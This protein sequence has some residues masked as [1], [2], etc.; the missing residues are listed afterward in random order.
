M[1]TCDS[2]G[3]VFTENRSLTRHI[4]SVHNKNSFNCFHC[5]F[6]SNRKDSL[7]RHIKSK[8]F[9]KCSTNVLNSEPQNKKRRT[10][11]WGDLS[12]MDNLDPFVEPEKEKGQVGGDVR[13]ENDVELENQVEP[14][15]EKGQVGGDDGVENNVELENQ[16]FKCPDCSL[17]LSTRGSLYNHIKVKHSH[18]HGYICDQ[19]G[20]GFPRKDYLIKHMKKHEKMNAKKPPTKV[21][22]RINVEEEPR[23]E[24]DDSS[25]SESAFNRMLLTKTWRIRG[26]TDPLSLMAKYHSALK[27][28]LIEVL[29]KNAVK[30]YINV[31][32]TMVRKD[33]TGIKARSSSYLHGSTR[34][35]LRASQ[36]PEM[37]QSS[38]EKINQ[39]F[40]VFLKNG[41][42]WVLESIDYL[43]LFTAE[44]A[45]MHGNR[46]IPTP[47][48]IVDKHAIINP[49]NENEHCVMYCLALSQHYHEIDQ[50]NPH[51]P[52]QLE[53]FFDEYN[54]DGCSMPMEIDDFT[55]FEK[56]NNLAIN[57]YHIKHDG[58]LITPLRITQQE[59]KLEEYVNL[60]LIEGKEHCHYAWI[61]NLDR[62]LAYG[63]NNTRKFCPF[64]L[65]GFDTRYKKTLEEHLPL[66]REYGGQK[67]ILPA[68]GKNIIEFKDHHKCLEHPIVIYADFESINQQVDVDE[69]NPQ[70][71]GTTLNTKHICS[72]YSYTVV[73]PHCPNRVKTYR[74]E[75]AGKHFLESVMEE[76]IKI[77]KWL[78]EIEKKEHNLNPDEEKQWQAESKCHI[79][80][81]KFYKGCKPS[82]T[83]NEHLK[84]HLKEMENLL[85]ANK[86]DISKIPSLKL[87][88]KQKR[89]ISLQLHPDKLGDVSNEEKHAKEEELKIFNVEN[90][91]LQNYLLEHEL[92][93]DEEQDEE[94]EPE[95]DLTA[96]EIDRIK[97]KGWKV[98]DHDHWTGQYRGAAHSGCN[99]ALRKTRKIPVIFH[100]LTGKF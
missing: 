72:G 90:E 19:C 62:L 59:G 46:Y 49:H 53:Q 4:T 34:I 67:T 40:D 84:K 14:E 20:Q 39:S 10:N 64:C 44:Y 29:I 11:D 81:D 55:K 65:Q 5:D 57:V 96:E 95:D 69:S 22:T 79:C 15:K 100:N 73:S 66:C 50:N 6:V 76:E 60:L 52:A 91:N 7:A 21:K 93:V 85:V 24:Y 74:G 43:R 75:D 37:L 86:L 89:I 61:K 48:A 17:S 30:M 97:K 88:K 68:K 47:K 41:S 82:A 98:R 71:S 56:N 94:F 18:R 9:P 8:H 33:Q 2:C 31:E 42:G 83:K 99:L 63:D 45:P 3:D 27:R 16:S 12:S 70:G 1:F 54:F 36:I 23:A 51:R 87:V 13:V 78:K 77:S 26:A 25:T 32:I 28:T 58:K 38:T 35:L 92:L 80:K